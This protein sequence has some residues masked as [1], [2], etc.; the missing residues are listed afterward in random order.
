MC[1][2][3]AKGE[4]ISIGMLL[5]ERLGWFFLLWRFEWVY[6]FF[7]VL[8]VFVST[9]SKFWK[10]KNLLTQCRV[11]PQAVVDFGNRSSKL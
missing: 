4:L 5:E 7:G 9:T 3:E 8:R 10:E 1:V 2:S 11:K 6:P